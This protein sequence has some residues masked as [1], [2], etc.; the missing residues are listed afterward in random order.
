MREADR[1]EVMDEAGE[2]GY[3]MHATS[4]DPLDDDAA[5]RELREELTNLSSAI[6]G[7]ETANYAAQ[8]QQYQVQ[9]MAAGMQQLTDMQEKMQQMQQQMAMLNVQKPPAAPIYQMAPL[10]PMYQHQPPQ[11]QYNNSNNGNGYRKKGKN[12]FNNGWSNG[13]TFQQSGN[14]MSPVERF[15]NENYCYTCS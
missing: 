12:N 15:E 13:N 1:M 10:P 5:T 2:H 7:Q 9:Q 8:Q 4:G 14:V 3:G 11:Q 6:R